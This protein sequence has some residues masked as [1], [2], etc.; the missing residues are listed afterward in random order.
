MRRLWLG[1]SLV[2]FI[3][4]GVL[5]WVG[6]RIYQLAPPIP[7][8]VVTTD[9]RTIFGP[10]EVAAGQDVWRSFGGMELGSIWGH[11]SYVAPDWSA[12]WLH[13]ELVGQLD[14]WSLRD[15]GQAY[16]LVAPEEQ[17]R[18]RERLRAEIRANT[19]DQQTRT[20]R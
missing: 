17:A 9:G 2:L 6:S 1:L 10:G 4:F 15:H 5:I 7:D 16:S 18:G 19:F 3:S 13:R 14:H 20:S 12:D 8:R 11:G